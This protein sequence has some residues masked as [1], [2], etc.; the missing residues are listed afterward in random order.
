MIRW[1]TTIFIFVFCITMA[2]W[3]TMSE[4]DDE[5]IASGTI[6]T[7]EEIIEIRANRSGLISE[8][9]FSRR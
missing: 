2:V 9:L 3:A 1:L 4:I 6:K 8:I 5:F 7:S